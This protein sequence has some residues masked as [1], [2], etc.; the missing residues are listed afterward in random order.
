M[1]HIEKVKYYKVKTVRK[2]QYTS[3]GTVFDSIFKYNSLI[4]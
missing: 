3:P 4:F 2:R 1:T